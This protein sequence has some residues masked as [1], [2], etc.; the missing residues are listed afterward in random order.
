MKDVQLWVLTGAS[1]VMLTI[2][3]SLFKIA[4]KRFD[5]LIGEVQKLNTTVS[6]QSVKINHMSDQIVETERRMN[7]H[8]ERIRDLE[9]FKAKHEE[10]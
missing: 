4:I 5:K 7:T 10:K 2:I 6:N 3:I 8:S 1:G 9:L